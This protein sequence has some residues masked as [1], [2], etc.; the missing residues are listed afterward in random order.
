MGK[1]VKQTLIEKR[2][3]QTDSQ[4][5]TFPM[6][7]VPSSKGLYWFLGETNLRYENGW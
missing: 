4:G 2:N 6:G 7:P 1:S 5:H 3:L